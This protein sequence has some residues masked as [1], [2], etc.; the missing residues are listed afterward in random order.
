MQVHPRQ[1]PPGEEALQP[2]QARAGHHLYVGAQEGR[3][4]DEGLLGDLRR[5][6]RELPGRGCRQNI[7]VQAPGQF[8][9]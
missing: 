6:H 7:A 4:G 2:G 3:S 1:G 5:L 9:P 8:T